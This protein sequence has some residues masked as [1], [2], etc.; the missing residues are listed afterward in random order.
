MIDRSVC[1]GR[2][3]WPGRRIKVHPD[4]L[5]SPGGCQRICG[6][7][8]GTAYRLT[9]GSKS[10]SASGIWGSDGKLFDL[11]FVWWNT[12]VPCRVNPSGR[13]TTDLQI[14]YYPQDEAIELFRGIG[15]KKR[16]KDFCAYIIPVRSKGFKTGLYGS[17][18]TVVF[19]RQEETLICRGCGV[20]GPEK[21]RC[22]ANDGKYTSSN[23]LGGI[24]SHLATG[25]RSIVH[26][27]SRFQI[28]LS[29][30][31]GFCLEALV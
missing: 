31:L 9:S 29:V 5:D 13:R 12:T 26:H 11:P 23:V 30:I 18:K 10:D 8:L 3:A 14:E 24:I 25:T 2:A 21:R 6:V 7:R 27:C 22:R 15:D 28:Y 1:K 4:I 17:R 19:E 16:M 20:G